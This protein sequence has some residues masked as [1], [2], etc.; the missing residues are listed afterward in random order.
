MPFFQSLAERRLSP[1]IM[2]QPGLDPEAHVAALRSLERINQVSATT[3]ILWN[4]IRRLARRTGNPLR[5]LDVA[6]GG[7]GTIRSLAKR[8]G[9]SAIPVGFT[10]CDI[11]PTAIAY[12]RQRADAHQPELSFFQHDILAGPPPDSYDVVMCS[13]FLHHVDENEA[14]VVLENL[15]AAASRLLLVQDLIR[16]PIA[17]GVAYAGTRMLS[18]S[19]IVHYDGPVSVQ[20]A[21]TRSEVRL[22]AE[23]CGMHDARVMWKWP[24]RFLLEWSQT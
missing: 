11:S 2:D 7:G 3:H 1:E 18:R 19:P 14:P 4:P 6:C 10:G 13:L 9:E 12:A 8:A 5:V 23:R 16:G 22:L 17:Y 15:K 20:R 24:F 21:F